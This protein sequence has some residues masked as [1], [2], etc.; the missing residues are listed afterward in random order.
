MAE[1]ANPA[2]KQLWERWLARSWSVRQEETVSEDAF[3]CVYP[4][5]PLQFAQ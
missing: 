4:W 3:L 5:L 2:L 1:C